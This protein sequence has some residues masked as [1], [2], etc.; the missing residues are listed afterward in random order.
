M[1]TSPYRKDFQELLGSDPLQIEPST[2]DQA[3]S[4]TD[5]FSWDHNAII[6]HDYLWIPSPLHVN[7]SKCSTRKEMAELA[8]FFAFN[9]APYTNLNM[10]DEL[11]KKA[12]ITYAHMWHDPRTLG[13]KLT[14]ADM[15]SL[16]KSMTQRRG[17]DNFGRCTSF[18]EEISYSLRR[19]NLTHLADRIFDFEFYDMNKHR[20]A[21]CKNTGLVIDSSSMTG[22]IFL[23]KDE[24]KVF[25][26]QPGQ[27]KWYSAPDVSRTKTFGRN[28]S[29]IEVIIRDHLSYYTNTDLLCR[30]SPQ[31][32][33]PG[34]MAYTN[35][36]SKSQMTK[37]CNHSV[38]SGKMFCLADSQ[39]L[40]LQHISLHGYDET[41]C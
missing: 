36:C 11:R 15:C 31:N 30:N 39:F 23:S 16:A 40:S 5:P 27:P 4:S 34:L 26:D 3:K 38:F 9:H 10:I 33:S 25:P 24:W 8:W 7:Y 12:N 13:K 6:D 35:A 32:R 21:R 37:I 18:A 20:L 14:K 1:R 28:G 41:L 19:A 2:P 17:E 29:S 22:P